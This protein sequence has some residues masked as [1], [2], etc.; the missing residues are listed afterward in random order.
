MAMVIAVMALLLG[1]G[2][3]AVNMLLKSFESGQTAQGVI[4]AAL[5][6]ARALAVKERR[7]VG[8]RFQPAYNRSAADPLDPL[9]APQ[10]MIFIIHD[11]EAAPDGTGLANGFRAIEGHKP[12]RLPESVG[13]MDMTL[14]N[15]PSALVF[16]EEPIDTDAEIDSPDEL[17]ETMTFSVVFSPSGKLVVH[18]VR[19]RNR[20]GT[21]D[22]S[23]PQ[24]MDDVFNTQ[25]QVTAPNPAGEFLQDDYPALGLGQEYSRK[26]FIIYDRIEFRRA[27]E[28]GRAWSDYLVRLVPDATYINPYTGTIIPRD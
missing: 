25:V 21:T 8:L 11:P 27:F 4:S 19:V 24:S 18:E 20:N 2:L 28:A 17:R 6:S 22:G 5:T 14:V 7:Y 9:A 26:S 12:I 3:P 15:R 10:Y 23:S 13:V 1:A 16:T